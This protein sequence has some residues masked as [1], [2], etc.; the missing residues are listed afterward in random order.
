MHTESNTYSMARVLPDLPTVLV[1]H[2]LDPERGN[3]FWVSAEASLQDQLDH[4]AYHLKLLCDKVLTR[5]HSNG[6]RNTWNM[7]LRRSKWAG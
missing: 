7:D 6:N 2:H 1:E 4:Y 3:S 5:S